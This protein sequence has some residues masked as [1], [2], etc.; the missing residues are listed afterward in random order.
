MNFKFKISPIA[1]Q[2]IKQATEY[3]KANSSI[4]VAQNFIIDYQNTISKIKQIPYLQ[5]YYKNYRG[6]SL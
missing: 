1:K 2:N 5:I 3:Y 6:I 4:K